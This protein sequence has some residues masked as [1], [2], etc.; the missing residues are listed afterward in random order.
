MQTVELKLD[1]FVSTKAISF[2][3]LFS[4]RA[5]I[6][7]S[8]S[9]SQNNPYNNFN[10]RNREKIKDYSAKSRD[11]TQREMRKFANQTAQNVTFLLDHLLQQYDNSLRPDIRGMKC[12][13]LL[14]FFCFS[15][16]IAVFIYSVVD[17]R[18]M[19]VLILKIFCNYKNWDKNLLQTL[20][21][22]SREKIF[23]IK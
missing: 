9:D 1:F 12:V 2:V 14:S 13:W 16:Q 5:S 23:P 3:Y 6:T 7:S 4:C 20:M 10:P 17:E 21:M 8:S 11:E 18:L 19:F 15:K 22:Q